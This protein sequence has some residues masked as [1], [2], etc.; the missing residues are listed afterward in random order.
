VIAGEDAEAARV[1]RQA[2]V[3]PELGREV[4]DAEIV[5]PLLLLP[6]RLHRLVALEPRLDAREPVEILRREKVLEV[7]VGE[8]GEERRRIVR[9]LREPA[10]RELG[11]EETRLRRPRERQVARDREQ[12]LAQ[13]RAVVHVGHEA[14]P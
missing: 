10:R 6:P 9:E 8:L 2:L 4:R 7:V 11:K 3:E 12:R 14:A 1:D 13:G 5:R